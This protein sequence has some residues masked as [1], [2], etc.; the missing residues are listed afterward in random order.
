LYGGDK[1]DLILET[2]GRLRNESAP[3]CSQVLNHFSNYTVLGAVDPWSSIDH[4]VQ[5]KYNS[6]NFGQAYSDVMKKLLCINAFPKCV[7]DRE[8]IACSSLCKHAYNKCGP[9][10]FGNKYPYH[11][12]TPDD[13]VCTDGTDVNSEFG[14]D[15][16]NTSGGS[17]NR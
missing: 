13:V 8:R 12:C 15:D 10:I 3:F 9:R 2:C 1:C 7:A 14:Y 6:T 5:S 4:H 17:Y 16:S 11:L